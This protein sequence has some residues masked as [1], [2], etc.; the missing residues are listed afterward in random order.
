MTLCFP[1]K[2]SAASRQLDCHLQKDQGAHK[3]TL[4]T[5]ASAQIHHVSPVPCWSIPRLH[6]NHLV[7]TVDCRSVSLGRDANE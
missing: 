1:S 7:R 3:C 5:A 2:K 4:G 6:P